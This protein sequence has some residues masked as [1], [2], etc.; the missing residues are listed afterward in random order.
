M[1]WERS[2]PQP[3]LT[4]PA[5]RDTICG[6]LSKSANKVADIRRLLRHG[7]TESTEECSRIPRAISVSVARNIAGV[8]AVYAVIRAS[9]RQYRVEEKSVIDVNR[10]PGEVGEEV[11]LDEVLMVAGDEG[12]QVG[13]PLV[14]GAKVV[15]KVVRQ[16]KGRK[17][18]GF[19]Y[20]AK[21]NIRRRFGHRQ[22]LTR[23]SVERIESSR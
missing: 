17:V 20:K 8:C 10:M 3:S 22:L 19:T 16:Y 15:G 23:L 9:G 2:C 12:V 18:V 5:W 11:E 4:R 21:K 7:D 1:R 13:S 6:L 14:A